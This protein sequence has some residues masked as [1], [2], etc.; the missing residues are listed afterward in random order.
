MQVVKRMM[1]LMALALLA[2]APLSRPGTAGEAMALS[3]EQQAAVQRISDFMN[4]FTYLEGEFTQISPKGNTSRGI[5]Y[6]SKPGKMRFE[7]AP[8]NPF[9]IVADGKWLTIKNRDKEQGDQFPL[10]ETPLRIVLAK[11]VDILKDSRVLAFEEADGLMAITLEDKGGFLG[12]QLV[13]VYDEVSNMLQQWIVID[14]KGRRTSVSLENVVTGK[15]ADPKLFVVKIERK[16]K[17]R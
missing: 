9:L 7:Y 8:P 1:V 10:S 12:G 15:E 3:P 14:N 13:L 5:F 17:L 6:I 11:H 4:S 16:E 2:L